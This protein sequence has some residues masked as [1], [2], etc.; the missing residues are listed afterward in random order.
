M[1]EVKQNTDGSRLMKY[2]GMFID[3]RMKRRIQMED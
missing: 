2:T 3:I 1:K